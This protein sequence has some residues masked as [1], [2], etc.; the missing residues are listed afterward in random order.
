VQLLSNAIENGR[1]CWNEKG[2]INDNEGSLTKIVVTAE[3]KEIE[4][5]KENP[6]HMPL[7]K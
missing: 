5:N 3:A 6:L 1:K 2:D 4:A 7:R